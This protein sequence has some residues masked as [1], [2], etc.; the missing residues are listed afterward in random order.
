MFRHL[1]TLSLLLVLLFPL[2][3][4]AHAQSDERCFDETLFCISGRFREYWE[5]NGGLA[6]FGYPL[7]PAEEQ[8]NADDGQTYLTQLFERQRF[9]LHPENRRPY[10]V[11]LGRLGINYL[12]ARGINWHGEPKGIPQDE[13]LWFEETQH[14]V[15]D[16]ELGIGFM[17]YWQSNGLEFDGSPGFSYAESLALFGMP[18]T[19]ARMETNIDGVEVLTQVFERA[20]FEWHPDEPDAF[21]VLLGL[22]GSEAGGVLTAV[23][24]SGLPG[25]LLV[26][27]NTM[28]EIKAD[29]SEVTLLPYSIDTLPEALFAV[30]NDRQK[31][32]QICSSD[33]ETGLCIIDLTNGD[34]VRINSDPSVTI[35]SWSPDD[36]RIGYTSSDGERR[37]LR[38]IN[39]DGS[40][41]VLLLAGTPGLMQSSPSWSPDGTQLA[42]STVFGETALYVVNAD[43]SNLRQIVDHGRFPKWSPTSDQ[44]IFE[45]E[46]AGGQDIWSVNADGTN[47]TQ[48][49]TSADAEVS[50]FW[51]PDGTHIAYFQSGTS[52]TYPIGSSTVLSTMQADGSD[53]QIVLQADRS[54]RMSNL[55][56]SPDSNYVAVNNACTYLACPGQV[57]AARADGSESFILVERSGSGIPDLITWLP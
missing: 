20:R 45:S 10:D 11:L 40:E 21:K 32:A 52:G 12:E 51:S 8:V 53:Q 2:A 16:Q 28:Y 4:A 42:F 29:G 33:G 39:V 9:E 43:G 3:T 44:I 14:S 55:T 7:T 17:T 56:W 19:E 13:C 47:L 26:Q 23:E 5:Q 36:Q 6:V 1:F 48:L 25:R 35:R 38:V 31:A 22:L 30:S 34:V 15:C 57:L 41:D 49:T 54:S 18:L 46:A 27:G 37:G 50:P 24:N